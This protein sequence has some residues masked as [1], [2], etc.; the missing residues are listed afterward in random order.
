[1]ME[2]S[3]DTPIVRS[4]VLITVTLSASMLVRATKSAASC[5]AALATFP[6]GELAIQ[7]PVR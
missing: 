3:G 4:A 2:T 6:A 5:A 1:M 7:K